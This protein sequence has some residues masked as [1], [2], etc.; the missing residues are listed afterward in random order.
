MT[1]DVQDVRCGP[2]QQNVAICYY[3]ITQCVPEKIAARLLKVGATLGGC[4]TGNNAARL[5]VEETGEATVKLSLKAFPNPVQDLVTVE[6]LAPRAGT[7]HFSVMDVAGRPLQQRSEQLTEGLN[8]VQFR[9][10]T[11]PTGIYLI[12]AV[13]E[14]SRQGVVRVSKQ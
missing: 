13:D 1:V 5:G 8:E 10:G 9:L 6:V 14:E 2:V 12:R 4:S 3:G 11:L 7:A